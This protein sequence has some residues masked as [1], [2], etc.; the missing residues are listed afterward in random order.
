MSLKSK[1]VLRLA[2]MVLIFAA[3]MFIPAGSFRFWQGWIFIAVVFVA[4]TGALFYFCKHDPKLVERRLQSKEKVPEQKI[5]LKVAKPLFLV[6]FLLPGLD[7]RFGWSRTLLG[8]VPLWL[9]ALSQALVLG[10][11]LFVMWVMKTNSFAA[12]T[13]QVEAGQRKLF[14]PALTVSFAI[15]CLWAASS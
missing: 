9:E 10:A 1:L 6:A 13:I 4:L 11:L 3:I 12:R 14:P 8:G 7:Y 5:L 15:P 2:L